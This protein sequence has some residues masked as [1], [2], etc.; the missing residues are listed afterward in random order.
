MKYVVVGKTFDNELVY[1]NNDKK[2][3]YCSEEYATKFENEN[4]A[5]SACYVAET[6]LTVEGVTNIHFIKIR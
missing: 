1:W 4:K 3:W 2:G 5:D 6:T